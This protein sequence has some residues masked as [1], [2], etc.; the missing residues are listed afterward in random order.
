MRR[1]SPII[2]VSRF[3]RLSLGGFAIAVLLLN[4]L[5]VSGANAETISGALAKAY[6]NNPDLNAQRAGLRATDEG[7]GKAKSGYRPSINVTADLGLAHLESNSVGRRSVGT[8]PRGV[9]LTIN[10]NI[11]NGFR[12]RNGVRQSQ[13][14]ILQ[15][16]EQLRLIEQSVLANGAAAYMNV[17]RDAA[18]IKLQNNN[19][20][21]LQQQLRTTNDRF[22]VGEVTRTDVAQSESSLAQGQSDLL[23][24][25]TNLQNS[26][27]V[28]RQI[29]GV[30]PR[31][32]TP[33][34]PLSRLLP[35][36]RKLAL[37]YALREHPA[38][39]SAL[40]NVDVAAL[41]V[42]V[43][44]GALYP[45]VDITGSIRKSYDAGNAPG[46]HSLAASIIGRLSVPIYQGGTEY[47]NI[48][49][50]KEQLGQARLLV[51]VQRAQVRAA[52]VSAWGVWKSSLQV[53][54]ARQSAV[55]AA[56]IAL[57][58][59][60]EEAKVGQRTTLDVLNAQQLLLNA[61]VNIITAQRDRVVASYALYS[62]IGKLS[63]RNLRLKVRHYD[64]AIHFR[65]VKDKLW[66]VRVPSGR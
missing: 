24:A 19:I 48:R 10:Q 5:H 63:S 52:L 53:I 7:I 1:V 15:A 34:R 25:Q 66:G 17:L 11:F 31:R 55:R 13:Y 14:Q 23:L 9:G 43:A 2:R 21:V 30:N 47:A 39:V 12:T 4:A 36:S 20:K 46:S 27:A 44:E 37:K 65:Q 56:E 22:Q 42:K 38:I 41:A 57:N 49:Q 45:S 29:I 50:T 61:R 54:R 16:R 6:N 60:R 35:R 26:L 40:H 28:Y 64:P 62:A 32:L 59:V 33:A 18:I 8:V 51:D 3:S 58:G